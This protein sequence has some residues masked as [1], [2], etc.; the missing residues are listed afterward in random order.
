MPQRERFPY[1]LLKSPLVDITYQWLIG[2]NR[3][4]DHFSQR[5]IVSTGA[6]SVLDLGC[7]NADLLSFYSPKHY[8]G[9]DMNADAIACARQRYPDTGRHIQVDAL[10]FLSDTPHRYDLILA[11]GLLHHLCDDAAERLVALA[12]RALTGHGRL[13]TIDPLYL[14]R[15]RMLARY[16]IQLDRGSN[17]RDENGY[18]DIAQRHFP[19]VESHHHGNLLRIPYD[20]FVM[21]CFANTPGECL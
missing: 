9:V 21:V 4:R 5:Y 3:A 17:I 13:V 15:Q 6:E 14:P 8:T 18:L 1:S 7:G 2:A 10:R 19:C 20:H 11:A 16:L 12:R